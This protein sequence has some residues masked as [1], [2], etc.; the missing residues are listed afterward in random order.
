M[1]QATRPVALFDEL[2]VPYEVVA[3]DDGVVA[4]IRGAR[5]ELLWRVAQ[6]TDALQ[7][8]WLRTIP[9]FCRVLTDAETREL[10]ANERWQP[11]EPV[12][13]ASG[14]PV[15]SVWRDGEG[16]VF[17]PFD[18]AA[19]MELVR[20]E[21]YLD[22]AGRR[23]SAAARAKRG[24]MVAYYRVRPLLPRGLQIALR[25]RFAR[26]Q[27]RATFPRWPFEPALHD[28]SSLLLRLAAEVAGEPVPHIA[29]WPDGYRWALV[30]THDVET[31]AGVDLIPTLLDVESRHGF[32]STWNFVPRRYDVEEDVLVA[33]RDAGH[34]IGVHGLYHD[35]RDLEPG[36]VEERLP[37]MRAAADRWGAVG[38]R[39]PAT[40]RRWELM[41]RLGFDWD[42]SYFDTDPFEPQSGGCCTWLP[43]F[44]ADLVELPITLTQDHTAFVILERDG[45]LWI[46][47]V[48][49]LRERG[50]MALL[51]THPD[52][53]LDGR[54]V[55]AYDGLL[56]RFGSDPTMWRPLPRDVSAWWRRRAASRLERDGSGWR[57]VGPAADEAA[58]AYAA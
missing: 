14:A 56:T 5:G 11:D 21:R 36:V 23:R 43:F 31:R 26:I 22:P 33:L 52:Y 20:S 38:F 32:H 29:S 9:L 48:E 54:L 47:K 30:L 25:R 18:P 46:D 6:E 39:S 13:D 40:H 17:L 27:A 10:L 8:S 19:A 1:F 37:E 24:A 4:R 50:G 28:L 51:N 35:G 3:G 12:V 7:P 2:R 45:G 42:S 55:R 49:F 16:G 57:V 34:E 53:Q 41:P 58:V 44:N 15:G